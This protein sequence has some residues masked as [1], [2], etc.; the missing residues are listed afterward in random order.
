M[1]H[2]IVSSERADIRR[3]NALK[4]ICIKTTLVVLNMIASLPLKQPK[5]LEIG[6][7][8]GW[9]SEKLCEFGTVVGVD[10]SPRAIEIAKRRGTRAEFIPMDFLKLEWPAS[11]FDRI[12][13]CE[14]FL[15]V[16]DQSG[17][18]D[19]MARLTKRHGYLVLGAQNKFVYDRRSDIR[20][21]LPD[22]LRSW[23]S[24]KALLQLVKRYFSVLQ[25][26]TVAPREDRGILAVINSAKINWVLNKLFSPGAVTRAKETLDLGDRRVLV[27]RRN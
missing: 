14:T 19:R 7:G 15:N 2:G 20:P 22:Q 12:V 21:P 10:L 16:N 6:C 11:D 3:W 17:F 8:T 26:T 23:L 9:H 24:R 1:T 13:C 4:T 27:G 18:M 5:I 25:E